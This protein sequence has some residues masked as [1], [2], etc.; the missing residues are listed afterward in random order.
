MTDGPAAGGVPPTGAAAGA[1]EHWVVVGAGSAGCVIA[2]RL[3]ERPDRHVTLLE[4]GPALP[5]GQV[6]PG[7]DGS[8][9]FAALADPGRTFQDLCATR[10]AGGPPSPYLRGRGVGGSSAVN[11]MVALRG[12]REQYASWGWSDAGQAWDRV[13]IPT[14][15]ANDHELGTVDRA[16]LAALSEAAPVPLTRR[17]GR[18][19]TSAEAYLW[20]ARDR[21]NL[22]V[23]PDSA[24]ARVVFDAGRT[25][26]VQLGDGTV[27]DADRV[28]VAAGA[29]HSPALLLRSGVEVPGLGLGL[30]DHPSAV[31]T[32]ALRD[33]SDS[34]GG[35]TSADEP[36]SADA[37]TGDGNPT[38]AGP[39]AASTSTPARCGSGL[40]IGSAAHLTV[41]DSVIQLLP[42][43][44]L[45]PA[46]GAAGLGALMVALMTPVGRSGTVTID[47]AGHP[48]VDFSLL[49][50]A[51]DL[52][53]LVAGTRLAL[54][55]LE[56]AAFRA[57]VESVYI[58]DAGTTADTLNGP[59]AIQ[60][61]LRARCGDYVH[62][63]GTCAMGAVV[64]A[65][66]RVIGHPGLYVC[67]ASI[68]PSIPHANTHLPTTMAA[69]RFCLRH[70]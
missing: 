31:F 50:D 53:A 28:V 26:G 62:A 20:P 24:V 60:D 29:I 44:H 21:P 56:R 17:T 47:A 70:P 68:F 49:S 32:L 16:L 3:S 67:D 42:L 38:A 7:I 46:P 61:W 13:A 15:P 9:F 58:D 45:G 51:R 6:P 12:D 34:D 52:D 59:A 36:T 18:R 55:V 23:S 63:S 14:E 8:D 48:V 5:P 40:A 22:S 37:P 66:Y 57:V 64:D 1:A 2:A 27:I 25:R 4:H 41:G 30:Q 35:D 54:D 10:T 11:A 43:N 39:P 65:D 19:V 69:E 33:H